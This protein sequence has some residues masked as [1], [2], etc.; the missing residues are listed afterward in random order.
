MK[1]KLKR[2]ITAIAMMLAVS[3]PS[4]ALTFEVDGIYYDTWYNY[5]LS[6]NEARVTSNT[7][8]SYTGNIVIPESVTY[9]GTIYPVTYI[10][11]DAFYGCTGLTEVTIPNSVTA[12]GMR[13]F[14]GCTGLTSIEIPNS[15]T[16]IESQAFENCTGLTEVTIPNSVTSIGNS[17]F[18]RC[19][20][21]TSIEIPNSVTSISSEAF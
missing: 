8:G 9:S 10:D 7:N 16:L 12:I 14:Y 13:A 6:R 18:R 20:S 11:W 19:S 4:M 5:E 1:S 3:L 17:A 2:A 21:L 15:V